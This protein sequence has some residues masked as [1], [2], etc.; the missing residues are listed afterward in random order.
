[1]RN[2]KILFARKIKQWKRAQLKFFFS[3]ARFFI[4][5][6]RETERV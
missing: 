4:F 2:H 3:Q 1:M 5:T 6:L